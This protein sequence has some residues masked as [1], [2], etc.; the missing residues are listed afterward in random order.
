MLMRNGGFDALLVHPRRGAHLVRVDPDRLHREERHLFTA[1]YT[2]EE[3][4]FRLAH[5]RLRE[6]RPRRR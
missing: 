4:H 3:A 5:F 6:T 1:C 2:R